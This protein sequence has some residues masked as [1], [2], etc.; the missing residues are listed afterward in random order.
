[1]E[2]KS[3]KNPVEPQGIE[4]GTVKRFIENFKIKRHA[5]L[6]AGIEDTG[7]QY[8]N[9]RSALLH[10]VFPIVQHY[11]VNE[12]FNELNLIK[13][14]SLRLR[15][16]TDFLVFSTQFR[17]YLNK[18]ELENLKQHH[19]QLQQEGKVLQN[20]VPPYEYRSDDDYGFKFF[21]ID[22]KHKYH[23][24]LHHLTEYVNT[25]KYPVDDDD[26]SIF[27]RKLS[28]EKGSTTIE[29][30][31]INNSRNDCPGF[32]IFVYPHLKSC[33]FYF[34]CTH[35]IMCQWVKNKKVNMY[36]YKKEVSIDWQN[37][38]ISFKRFL[39]VG[40]VNDEDEVERFKYRY[41]ENIDERNDLR[42]LILTNEKKENC[43]IFGTV[44]T[45]KILRGL[46]KLFD[47]QWKNDHFE[48]IEWKDLKFEQEDYLEL[49][50]TVKFPAECNKVRPFETE[51]LQ[52]EEVKFKQHKFK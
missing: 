43:V 36:N 32:E 42:L 46:Q 13:S 12:S 14:F 3:N 8:N 7:L 52:D 41:T 49:D 47:F 35:D 31:N 19:I 34:N 11:T 20:F 2:R 45:V 29:D 23:V 39:Y 24:G 10:S 5:L 40:E 18:R 38:V 25:G 27:H 48:H 44:E 22:K 51:K 28:S 37:D 17:R 50:T 6:N 21:Y 33:L 30:K 1:M 26:C 9:L 15:D 4:A 16:I